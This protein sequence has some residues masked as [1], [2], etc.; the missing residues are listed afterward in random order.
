MHFSS[1][2]VSMMAAGAMA[3]PHG[4]WGN[5]NKHYKVVTEY[6]YVTHYVTAGGNAPQATYVPEQPAAAPVQEQQPA[7]VVVKKPKKNPAPQ[8]TYVAAPEPEK[9]EPATTQEEAPAATQP[10]SDSGSGS[11]NLDADQQKAL[12]LHNEARKAVGN[13][14]LSWDDS[15][16][17]G[18]QEWADHLAQLGSLEHSQGEDGEN[19]YMGSGSNP[20]SAAVE[21]F[22]SEKSQ[23][24]GEAI[25]GSNYMS[26]GHYTQCVWKTTTKV[27]M[28]VAKDS[29]G[30]SWV[31]ARYQK[32]GNMIGDKPY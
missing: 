4:S 31:V 22:L 24:N 12:D 8:P 18:A 11:S 17:S 9:E 1:F 25:S 3:A 10:S 14:P 19:L 29:S 2:I 32:P 21:A 20:Y 28:A 30:A 15:L 5:S 13:E 7:P 27:G 16:A 23:Y 26:F 6:E